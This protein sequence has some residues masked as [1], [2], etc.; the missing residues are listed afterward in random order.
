[1]KEEK[2]K[3]IVIGATVAAVLLLAVLLVFMVYQLISISVQKNRER[4]LLEQIDA[5]LEY[6]ENAENDIQRYEG[7]AWLEIVARKLGMVGAGDLL[8]SSGAESASLRFENGKAVLTVY[9]NGDIVYEI[10]GD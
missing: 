5:C 9:K 4:E 3:K 10:C 6:I 7:Y 2:F 8:K 1:M